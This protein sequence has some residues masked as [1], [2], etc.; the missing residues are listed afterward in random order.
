[1]RTLAVAAIALFVIPAHAATIAVCPG[2]AI[3]T[4]QGGVNAAANGDTINVCAATYSELVNVNKSVTINGAQAGVDPRSG[5]AGSESI[6]NGNAGTTSFN[7]TASGV[8]INGFTVTDATNTNQFGTAIYINAGV[9]GTHLLNNIIQNSITGIFLANGSGGQA[10]IQHNLI[11]NNNQPG[12]VT[13]SGIYS[14]QFVAG[15]TLQNVLI[16]ANKLVGNDASGIEFD[17]S[18]T[19]NPATNITI[20]NNL[21]DA[22][23]RS[24]GLFNTTS[25]SITN[26]VF[27]NASFSGTADV[28][29]FEG[30][31]GLTITGN[32]LQNGA[33]RAF[34]ASNSGSL[35]APDPTNI[36]WHQN[37]I[38]GYTGSPQFFA[39]NYTGTLDA[40]CNWW[41]SA[42][43][44]TVASNPGGTGTSVSDN[45]NYQPWLDAPP[46]TGVCV[47]GATIA[48][49]QGSPQSTTVNTAFGTALQVKVS[50]GATPLAGIAVT[51]APVAGGSGASG[52]FGGPTTVLTDANGLATAPTLTA[53]T[54]PGA[55]TVTATAGASLS[56]TFNLTNTAGAPA[57]IIATQGTPQSTA[58]GTAF[59][60]AMQAT[61]TDAF[62][63]PVAGA[64]V[65]FT[66]PA[67]GASGTFAASATVPTNGAGVATAPAFTANTIPGSYS[68]TATTGGLTTTFSLTNLAGAPASISATQGT[69]QSTEVGTA[70][71]TA[72]QA[73]VLDSFGNPVPG[74]TVTFTPPSTGASATFSGSAAVTT[75]ASGVATAP[76]LTANNSAGSYVVTA[77]SS[78]GSAD[79]ILTNVASAPANVITSQGN[80]QTTG[81]GAPFATPLQVQVTDA[82]GNPVAGVVVTFTTPAASA[83]F[84]GGAASATGTTDASG[85]ASAPVLTAGALDGPFNVTAS[86]AGGA[87]ATF[88][89]SATAAIPALGGTGLLMLGLALAAMA[90]VV[91]RR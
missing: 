7:I 49:T 62:G 88:S 14:D 64:S 74:V 84:P 71:P 80:N 39:E 52:A 89:L 73:T 75:N 29:V 55:F 18:S 76:T 17:S 13:G 40:T 31:N 35:G 4:I 86:I 47:G 63:N 27:Q 30:V 20:S 15:G 78:A 58:V 33:G 22:N 1:M 56:T 67:S 57:A 42:S 54:I 36:A 59:P 72:L 12:A 66:A 79:F 16:D 48:V 50:N 24:V 85:F 21:F 43:G 68:V 44:P 65:T 90:L 19:A 82:F 9:S 83:T 25:S 46:P 34:R 6:V 11:Q 91:L 81:F 3:P 23:G 28:R 45:V 5:R 53:N 61:V 2:G 32:T 69:P 77:T 8:T 87:S 70:F 37:S 60:T 41:G 26:N 38:T 10:V 51:F